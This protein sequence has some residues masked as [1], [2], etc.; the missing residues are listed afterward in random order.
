MDALAEVHNEE[1][2]LHDADLLQRATI[3]VGRS[4]STCS[5]AP[6]PLASPPIV[7]PATHGESVGLHCDHCGRDG[8]VVAFC[9]RKRK[10]QKAQTHRSSQGTGGTSLGGSKRSSASSDTQEIL[11]LF[12]RLVASTL[13]GVVGSVT[14][15]SPF[16]GSAIASQSFSFGTTFSS[17]SRYL[18]V[19]Y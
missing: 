6:V 13:V 10:A 15:S 5:V 14:Q 16:I 18:S 2:R 1:T 19:V 11:M 12:H 7:P 3:L 8:H 9:Y 4:S 17:F